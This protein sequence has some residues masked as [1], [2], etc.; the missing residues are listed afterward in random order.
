M[1]II[2]FSVYMVFVAAL[3]ALYVF[4]QDNSEAMLMGM[5]LLSSGLMGATVILGIIFLK[6]KDRQAAIERFEM[7]AAENRDWEKKE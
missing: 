3:I 1:Y 4:C 7:R 6:E 2:A 5:Y